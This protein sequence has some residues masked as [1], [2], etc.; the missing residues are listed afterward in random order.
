MRFAGTIKSWDDERG[1][2]FIAPAQGGEHIFVHARAFPP[3]SGRPQVNQRVS[4]EVEPGSAGR[5]RAKNVALQ[6]TERTRSAPQRRT[7]AQWG[8]ST[9]FAMAALLLL[10]AVV[11]VLWRPPLVLAALYAGASLVTFLAYAAD[12]SAAR[13][14]T[15]RTPETT[16]H[17]LALACGWP[18]ALVAQQLLRHKSTK[19]AFRPV[20][21][22]TVVLNVAAFV[23]L[24]SPF[25]RALWT[26]P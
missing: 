4:F 3:R 1:F 10:Y 6:R 23:T 9:G 25:A 20:F 17:G 7:P 21:W 12:K 14:G 19:A 15:R 2:G 16:L 13:R 8:V 22:G 18:G 26:A 11:G 5:K 24:S